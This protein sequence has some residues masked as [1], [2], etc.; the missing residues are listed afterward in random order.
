MTFC[1]VKHRKIT[2]FIKKKKIIF[3]HIGNAHYNK[4]R[5]D[6]KYEKILQERAVVKRHEK[7]FGRFILGGIHLKSILISFSKN[8]IIRLPRSV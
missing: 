8:R 4:I 7:L 5:Y 3:V 6:N 1:T 2:N